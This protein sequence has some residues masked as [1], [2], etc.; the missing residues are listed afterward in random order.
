MID[1]M[2]LGVRQGDRLI[3]T[4]SGADAQEAV[5]AMRDLIQS[6]AGKAD[7]AAAPAQVVA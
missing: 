6:L 4:A 5:S 3:I 2:T 1:L 7:P